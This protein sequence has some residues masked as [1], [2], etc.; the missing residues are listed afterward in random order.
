MSADGSCSN[1]SL[2]PKIESCVSNRPISR[3]LQKHVPKEPQIDKTDKIKLTIFNPSLFF[4]Y[5]LLLF[6]I[7]LMPPLLTN[8]F[9][10]TRILSSVPPTSSF[11]LSN[12]WPSLSI[13]SIE[14]LLN[15]SHLSNSTVFQFT[16]PQFHL[17]PLQQTLVLIILQIPSIHPPQCCLPNLNW[18]TLPQS[19]ITPL[20]Q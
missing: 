1:T 19:H 8:F 17:G 13:L 4:V 3:H 12:E 9:F 6:L 20:T 18:T 7:K 5:F 15:E 16:P 14:C 10:Q 2:W 11:L